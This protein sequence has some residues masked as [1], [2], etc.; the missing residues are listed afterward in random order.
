MLEK[1]SHLKISAKIAAGL[2]LF[3]ALAIFITAYG[4]ITLNQNAAVTEKL[5]G[6]TAL[7][8]E[9]ASEANEAKTREHQIWFQT[10]IEN[11][12]PD[13]EVFMDEIAE[14][15]GA[16]D[17]YF[18]K[19]RPML[20]GENAANLAIVE[21]EMAT[22]R[23]ATDQIPALWYDGMRDEAEDV[24]Q[25]EA[26]EPFETMDAAL[27]EIVDEQR[28][29]LIFGVA[30]AKSDASFATWQLIIVSALGLLLIGGTVLW[31]V[32]K[33]IT[34]P[35]EGLTRQMDD[36]TAGRY[37]I[38]ITGTDRADEVGAIARALNVFRD[39]G[40]EKVEADKEQKVVVDTLSERLAT[41][42]EGDL[43]ANVD[44]EFAPA[45]AQLKRN[46]NDAVASLREL[47]GSVM[48]SAGAIRNG[49]NEIMQASEDLAR[50]TESNAASLEE[51]AAS[52]TEV[53][54]RVKAT[55]KA[56]RQTVTR[57]DEA[58]ET[59]GSGRS[60]AQC[61]VQAMERVSENAQ[62]IDAVIEGLD[63]IAFQTRVLAM[64]AA[65]E[66]GRAGEAGRGFAVVADLV[67]ALAMRA[68]EESKNAREQLTVTQTGISSAVEEVRKVDGALADIAT[69]VG[70]VHE[71]LGSMARDNEAQS[72]ALTQVSVAIGDMDKATQQNAAMV[73]ETS[74]A[75]RS[76]SGEVTQLSDQASRFRIGAAGSTVRTAKPIVMTSQPAADPAPKLPVA[77][78]S[79]GHAADG[80]WTAF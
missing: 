15:R 79:N 35:L 65:V 26:K 53:D 49:S 47:I 54:G 5:A 44:V 39:T 70:E 59:V 7:I 66:A 1:F 48:D 2:S 75:A 24:L 9:I 16:V 8:L 41:L 29:A 21:R 18:E 19:V 28:E 43:T 55:A 27:T 31:I 38:D 36:L 58:I 67:S 68:E 77:A 46:Y 51:T 69:G 3:V 42:A 22:Y 57:A 17:G 12:A 56:A 32:R 13:F 64:N 30:E 72:N 60:V 40:Q 45:Y 63:K 61:A 52:L 25:H 80:D 33:Q 74:A 6:E 20:S 78:M 34:Q 4:T 76:L 50:R 62:D 10:V 23:A 37:N 11:D 71:L 14:E 73:E